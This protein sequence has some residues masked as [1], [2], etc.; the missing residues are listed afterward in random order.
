MMMDGGEAGKAV[1][2]VRWWRVG[3]AGHTH[4]LSKHDYILSTNEVNPHWYIRKAVAYVGPF[5]CIL[6][7]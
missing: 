5:D 4:H 3:G 2:D 1:R 6:K 7:H